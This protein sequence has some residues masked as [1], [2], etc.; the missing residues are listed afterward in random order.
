MDTDEELFL[1]MIDDVALTVLDKI[2]DDPDARYAFFKR[3]V[4]LAQEATG[5]APQDQGSLSDPTFLI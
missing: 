5:D 2:G 1:D 4:E 3:F